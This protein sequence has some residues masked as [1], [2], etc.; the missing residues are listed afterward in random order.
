MMMIIVVM[1]HNHN[2]FYSLNIEQ[3]AHIRDSLWDELK[4]VAP[5]QAH[6][7]ARLYSGEWSG[8]AL[9]KVHM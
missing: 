8:L 3:T 4:G 7:H 2:I 6:M 1:I 9:T 5:T